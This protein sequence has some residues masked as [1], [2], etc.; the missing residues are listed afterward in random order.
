MFQC[1]LAKDS[2]SSSSSSSEND[3]EASGETRLFGFSLGPAKRQRKAK[4][5]KAGPFNV[6]RNAVVMD[7]KFPLHSWPKDDQPAAGVPSSSSSASAL[8]SVL[9]M[10]AAVVEEDGDVDPEWTADLG[11]H[12]CVPHQKALNEIERAHTEDRIHREIEEALAGA[13][14]GD[15]EEEEEAGNGASSSNQPPRAAQMKERTQARLPLALGVIGCSQS[16]M[17]GKGS[18]C[19]FCD[20]LITKGTWRFEYRFST[21]IPRWI[22]IGC[23]AS[24]PSKGEAR[25]NSIDFLRNLTAAQGRQF[26]DLV[27]QEIQQALQTLMLLETRP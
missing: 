24:I 20:Q 18:V 25:Q 11:E 3:N 21:K 12:D 19:Y 26:D 6:Q 9:H 1:F 17:R 22:H 15:K 2:D 23:V 13:E 8:Q 16:P 14:D 4:P 5:K 7:L 10:S 27:T